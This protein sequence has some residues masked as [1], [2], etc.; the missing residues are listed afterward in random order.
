MKYRIDIFS[1]FVIDDIRQNDYT[2][3]GVFQTEELN[4][5]LMRIFAFI[6]TAN[7]QFLFE[8]WDGNGH[9][10]KIYLD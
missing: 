3:Q 7:S 10:C 5:D 1:N 4:R 2:V 8:I 9:F 6:D